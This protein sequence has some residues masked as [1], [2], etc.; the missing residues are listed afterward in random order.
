[1]A[2]GRILLIV[3]VRVNCGR[4]GLKLDTVIFIVSRQ[5][6]VIGWRSVMG[7][8]EFTGRDIAR[9][10]KFIISSRPGAVESLQLL[11]LLNVV[12]REHELRLNLARQKRYQM[13]KRGHEYNRESQ[14]EIGKAFV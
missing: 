6:I 3:N 2:D 9:V 11:D 10:R 13:R 5:G 4:T 12:H 14:K 8:N 1:M 7:K